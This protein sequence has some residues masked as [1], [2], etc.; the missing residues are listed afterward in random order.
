MTIT[1]AKFNRFLKLL[2]YSNCLDELGVAV[3]SLGQYGGLQNF[4]QIVTFLENK[5]VNFNWP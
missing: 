5:S 2:A 4:L 1:P 3:Q